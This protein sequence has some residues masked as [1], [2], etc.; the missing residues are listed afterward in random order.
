[1]FLWAAIIRITYLQRHHT[2]FAVH[3]IMRTHIHNLIR[4]LA[5]GGTAAVVDLS[6]FGIFALYLNFNYLIVAGLGF[7]IATAVNYQLCV[8][9]IYTSG[10]R[11]SG[12]TE[13]F[14]IYVVS[15]VGLLLHEIAIYLIHENLAVSLFWSKVFAIGLIFVWNFGIRNFYVFVAPRAS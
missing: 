5:V 7:L 9:F 15:G 6:I 2:G 4:Y 10:E 1:M 3:H 14:S 13:V 8:R 11:F 12:R